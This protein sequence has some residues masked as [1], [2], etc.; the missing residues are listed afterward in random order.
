MVLILHASAIFSSPTAYDPR[1]FTRLFNIQ[2]K[3]K[4]PRGKIFL[5]RFPIIIIII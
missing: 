1:F 2:E 5:K 4:L 3:K